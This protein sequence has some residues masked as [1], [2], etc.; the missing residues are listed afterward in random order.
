M[1]R[2]VR[3]HSA[4]F[5]QA[6]QTALQRRYSCWV[7]ALAVAYFYHHPFSKA[8]FNHLCHHLVGLSYHKTL[9]KGLKFIDHDPLS[10]WQIMLELG[11]SCKKDVNITSRTHLLPL[12]RDMLENGGPIWA[13]TT[14]YHGHDIAITGIDDQYIYFYDACNENEGRITT[15]TFLD[16]W[17]NASS[18]YALPTCISENALNGIALYQYVGFKN[19]VDRNIALCFSKLLEWRY[20]IHETIPSAMASH[21]ILN[22]LN[23]ANREIENGDILS[24]NR[25]TSFY[26]NSPYHVAVRQI[27]EILEKD[28][29]TF[30]AEF[31]VLRRAVTR[32]SLSK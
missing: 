3:L 9:L 13:P 11:F 8:E 15:T 32:S 29:A 23:K 5:R 17:E 24:N 19:K 20:T 28:E 12:I 21:F 31:P 25:I 27:R 30:Q 1:T 16:K 18:R 6:H 26:S 10:Q 2:V 14:L 7:V 4:S 22:L